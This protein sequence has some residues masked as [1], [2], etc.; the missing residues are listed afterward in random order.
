MVLLAG[1]GG[2]SGSVQPPAAS[3]S[4][5][6]TPAPSP[7]GPLTTGPG[8]LPGEKPPVMP[9]E[10]REHTPEGAL[11]FA[12]YFM[13]ALDWSAATNDTYLVQQISDQS[14]SACQRD[15]AAAKA[16]LMEGARELGGR[17]RTLEAKIVQGTFTIQSD[18]VVEVVT[19]DE[20][21]V[22]ARPGAAPSTAVPA[23]ARD[24]SL[25]F[26]TWMRDGWR[27]V[28]QGKPS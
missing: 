13:K 18:Q 27:I 9:P 15:I 28:G 19:Q 20:P 6:A 21:V 7:T 11:A 14:C 5:S 24:T 12:S 1:C 17:T 4:A 23:L 25:V 26:V 16:L 10:A 2:E 22:I 8:V 3:T